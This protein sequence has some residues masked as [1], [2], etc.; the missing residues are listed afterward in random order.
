MREGVSIKNVQKSV[1]MVYEWPQMKNESM[2][3][4]VNTWLYG[5]SN[6]AQKDDAHHQFV[7]HNTHQ[8][9]CTAKKQCTDCTAAAQGSPS[10][11]EFSAF[12]HF[13]KTNVAQSVAE[14]IL[15][16]QKT[17]NMDIFNKIWGTKI[18]E[19]KQHF[20]DKMGFRL[21]AFSVA[22]TLAEPWRVPLKCHR[23]K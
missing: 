6:W 22:H 23:N 18:K 7:L 21:K 3:S 14:L 19:W 5:W 17:R 15:Y 10:M 9:K 11:C 4:L 2:V 8:C 1:H 12:R 13:F 20:H 16:S